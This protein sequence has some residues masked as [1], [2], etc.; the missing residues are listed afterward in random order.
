MPAD[1]SPSSSESSLFSLW[2][3]CLVL[4]FL[5]ILSIAPLKL[6][7]FSDAR[8]MFLVI[9]VYYWSLF[10]PKF[11]G[12]FG[13]FI[14]GILHDLILGLVLGTTS[15]ILI[16]VHVIMLRQRALLIRQPFT[17]LWAGFALLCFCVSIIKWAISSLIV[18]HILS[19]GFFALELLL[20]IACFPLVVLVLKI[21]N[22]DV[23]D[24]AKAK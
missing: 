7:V 18:L 13:V 19:P 1:L 15:F 20:T 5:F 9:A 22:T 6:G 11:L 21:G 23:F 8:P 14:L 2:P 16:G 12:I 17:I 3:P 10:R 24:Y 4:I